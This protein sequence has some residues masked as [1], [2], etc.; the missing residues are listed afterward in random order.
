MRALVI[1]AQLTQAAWRGIGHFGIMRGWYLSGAI[2]CTIAVGALSLLPN[3]EIISTRAAIEPDHLLAYWLL[4]LCWL[5]ACRGA[6]GII[7]AGAVAY[8]LILELLQV[9]IPGRSFE[10]MDVVAN[11]VGALAGWSS[12]LI[13]RKLAGKTL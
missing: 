13:A 2:G 7:L 4:T 1:N 11:T 8:G 5:L 10:L 3:A 6:G 9:S 12:L